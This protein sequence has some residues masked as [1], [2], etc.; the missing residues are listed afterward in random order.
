MSM[1]VWLADKEI[2]SADIKVYKNIGNK[3][4]R[5]TKAYNAIKNKTDFFDKY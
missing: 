2:Y 5:S 3:K 4:K 1:H